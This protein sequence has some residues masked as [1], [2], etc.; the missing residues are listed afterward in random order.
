L[1][2]FVTGRYWQSPAVPPNAITEASAS[3]VKE[4]ILLVAVGEHLERSRVVLAEIANRPDARPSD[5]APERAV[6][7]DLAATNRLYRQTAL[8]SGNPAMASA[9][10][11]L[12]RMLVEIANSSDAASPG[13]MARLRGRI[14]SQGLIFKV[15]VLGTQVRQRQRDAAAPPAVRT[16]SST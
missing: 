7:E 4:R 1:A 2:A 9:L 13:D 3:V 11:E 5:L 15:T 10:E 14:E 8:D 6:A 12:G 16:K